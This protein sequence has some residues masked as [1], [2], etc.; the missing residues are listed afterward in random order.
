M[1]L[2]KLQ[3]RPGDEQATIGVQITTSRPELSLNSLKHP[4]P[5]SVL[6]IQVSLRCLSSTQPSRAITISTSGSIFENTRPEHGYMDNLAQGRL[7]AGLV[8]NNATGGSKKTI[9]FGYFKVHRARQEG[10]D[11]PDLRQRPEFSFITIPAYDTG[12]KVTVTHSLTSERLFAFADNITPDDLAI[13]ET[14]CVSLREDYVGTTW[15][16]WGDL[17]DDL[18]GKKFHA[19]SKGT[20]LTW[21]GDKPNEEVIEKEGW[22][23]G[24]DV[25]QLRFAVEEEAASCLVEVVE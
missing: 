7:G 21:S 17:Q 13:G 23:I 2:F 10:D 16:C 24:D 4:T 25:A 14:Y 19:F 11:A 22:V 6:E 15:W 5:G 3:C 12:E 1:V 8:C 18:K 9:S 20:C